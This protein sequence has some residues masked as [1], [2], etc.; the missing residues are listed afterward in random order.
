MSN[1]QIKVWN[2]PSNNKD[3][4]RITRKE[5]FEFANDIVIMVRGKVDSVLLERI[6]MGLNYASN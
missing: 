4:Q 6:Q 5:V 2:R 1:G 3:H